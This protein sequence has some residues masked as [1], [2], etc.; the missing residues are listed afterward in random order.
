MFEKEIK[1]DIEEITAECADFE[2]KNTEYKINFCECENSQNPW[3]F[4]DFNMSCTDCIT[5][6]NVFDTE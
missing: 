6:F 1:H 4:E 5:P 3:D 2:H